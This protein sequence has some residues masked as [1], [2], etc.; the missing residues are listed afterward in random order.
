MVPDFIFDWGPLL[1]EP[2]ICFAI[3]WICAFSNAA[4][5]TAD[6]TSCQWYWICVIL[7]LRKYDHLLNSVKHPSITYAT[8]KGR[9][10]AEQ[11]TVITQT[12]NESMSI[13]ALETNLSEILFKW[14]FSCQENACEIS[15]CKMVA[16]MCYH[17]YTHTQACAYWLVDWILRSVQSTQTSAH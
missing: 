16:S 6:V 15:V 9:L 5:V 4:R 10:G 14:N 8:V 13:E 7:Q 1:E 12:I 3:C 2:A 11:A 17:I